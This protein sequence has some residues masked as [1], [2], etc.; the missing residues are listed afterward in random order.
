MGPLAE[1]ASSL[2]GR[3]EQSEKPSAGLLSGSHFHIAWVE[4]GGLGVHGRVRV[5][6]SGALREN[7]SY[8]ILSLLLNIKK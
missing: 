6:S 7:R 3:G 4:H 1:A 2:Q 8:A 5:Q